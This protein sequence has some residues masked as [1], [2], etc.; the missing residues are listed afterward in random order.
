[1]LVHAAAH[2]IE[3]GWTDEQRDAL[4]S[5]VLASLE[6]YLPGLSDRVVG[7]EVLTPA[8]LESRYALSGG[9]VFHGEH[10]LDQ[11]LVA[12]PT[13]KLAQHATPVSGLFLCSQGSHPGGGVT[14]APGVLGARAAL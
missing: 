3:G 9:H 11:A 13:L 5:T 10:A 2:E 6:R 8:D 14:C 4:G 1:I 12:R 7:S